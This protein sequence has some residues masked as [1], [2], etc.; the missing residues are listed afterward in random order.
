MKRRNL[1]LLALLLLLINS[2]SED[3][4]QEVNISEFRIDQN[5]L[6]NHEPVTI[7]S[8]PGYI[9]SKEEDFSH[10]FC[11]IGVSGTTGD[12]VNILAFPSYATVYES[13]NERYFVS[14]A[15]GEYEMFLTRFQNKKEI[16]KPNVVKIRNDV[17][18]DFYKRYPS[19][20][21]LLATDYDHVPVE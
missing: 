16:P 4:K 8:S 12:T 1:S 19:V 17:A 5:A 15:S 10:Y 7:I 11:L 9:V 14:S 2:C 3:S 6:R 13:D 21:G 20:I 18:L